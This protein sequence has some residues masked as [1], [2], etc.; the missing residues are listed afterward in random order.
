MRLGAGPVFAYEWLL[1]TRRWQLY[2][3]RAGFVLVIL[4]GMY[5]TLR[6]EPGAAGAGTTISRNELARY[7]RTFFLTIVSI[8]LAIV[9][10]VAP[11]VTAGAICVDKARGTLDHMLV[12]DLSSAEIVLGKL[13]VRLVPV[14]G[15]VACVLPLMAISALLGGID[16]SGVFGSFLAAIGCA[17]L[18]CTLALALSVWGRKPQDIIVLSYFI[19]TLWLFCRYLVTLGWGAFFFLACE[20]GHWFSYL[21][22]LALLLAYCAL[23]VS[24]GLALA[25]G[26]RRLERAVALGVGALVLLAIGWP[27]LVLALLLPARAADPFIISMVIGSPLYGVLF[28]THVVAAGSHNMPGSPPDIWTGCFLWAA[29]LGAAATAL[30]AI[31]VATFDRCLGRMPESVIEWGRASGFAEKPTGFAQKGHDLA[32]FPECGPAVTGGA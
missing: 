3:V 18:G 4:A 9:L 2:A 27:A 8:E 22:F 30:F 17:A 7:G 31:V 24:L 15:L 1:A 6:A 29:V 14:L 26:Q 16:P 19:F 12:T 13:G 32:E 25:T 20:S 28:A 5:F 10:L 23:V 11:A 21:N